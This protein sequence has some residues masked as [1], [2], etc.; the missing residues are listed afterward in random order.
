MLVMLSNWGMRKKFCTNI[1]FAFDVNRKVSPIDGAIPFSGYMAQ[2][3]EA[4]Q[5]SPSGKFSQQP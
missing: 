5:S 1:Y 3:Q 4:K 2:G